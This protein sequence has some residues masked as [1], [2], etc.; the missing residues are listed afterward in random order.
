M[1]RLRCIGDEALP[2]VPAE[3]CE[4]GD[5][6]PDVVVSKQLFGEHRGALVTILNR[7]EAIIVVLHL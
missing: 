3:G 2:F 5:E 1:E 7:P 6:V 4:V